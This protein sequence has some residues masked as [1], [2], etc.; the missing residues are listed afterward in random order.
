MQALLDVL[1]RVGVRRDV[2]ALRIAQQVLREPA[3]VAD[4]GRA[5]HQRLAR[6]RHVVGDRVDVVDE[7]HVEHAIGFVEH[8]HLDVVEHRLAGLQVVEQA[9][10]RRDQDVERAAQR[11]DLRRVRHAADHG[12]DAQALHVAAVGGRRLG[13]LHRELAG[14]R[15]HQ[16]A[17]AVDLAL[18]AALRRVG[19]R[20]PAC[21]AAPAG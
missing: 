5:V 6:R 9:A 7:A 17:R 11:L 8:E 10:G 18:F 12:R 3:D 19:A 1:V 15:Q 13:D 20:A 2:D 21:A 14:R 16:D 4:E